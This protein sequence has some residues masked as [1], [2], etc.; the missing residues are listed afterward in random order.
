MK[1]TTPSNVAP[2]NTS[3]STSILSMRI[4]KIASCLTCSGKANL[5]YHFGCTKDNQVHIRI[6]FNSGGGFFSEEWVPLKATLAALDKASHPVTAIPFINLFIGKS[7]NTPGFLL[8]VL[9]HEG[10]VK[11]LEGKVRGYE[12]LDSEP[13]MHEVN[14]L[15]SSDTDLKPE[16]VTRIKKSATTVP[17]KKSKQAL[18]PKS[19]PM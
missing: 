19:T 10:L 18:P 11:L 17:P 2:S 16:P 1:K 13:F 9:K 4:I 15:V 5:T 7:V 3:P 12:K 8:A 6:V 14:K